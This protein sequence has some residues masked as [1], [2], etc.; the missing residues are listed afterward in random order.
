[1]NYSNSLLIEVGAG[2]EANTRASEIGTSK[3]PTLL[4]LEVLSLGLTNCFS[5]LGLIMLGGTFLQKY[6]P[7]AIFI[8]WYLVSN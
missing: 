2:P 1:M 8:E 4:G 3:G 7:L 6:M 5:L